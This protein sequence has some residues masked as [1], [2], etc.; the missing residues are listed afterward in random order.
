MLRTAGDPPNLAQLQWEEW[1]PPAGFS[2]FLPSTCI[3][4]G[5]DAPVTASVQEGDVVYVSFLARLVTGTSGA[6][7]PKP[8][9]LGHVFLD[10]DGVPLGDAGYTPST[11]PFIV[12]QDNWTE[13]TY[14]TAAAPAGSRYVVVQFQQNTTHYTRYYIDELSIIVNP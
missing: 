9:Q 7:D 10:A 2:F 1:R 8:S 12:D 13:L 14:T 3:I 5:V 11:T 4:Q 6:S